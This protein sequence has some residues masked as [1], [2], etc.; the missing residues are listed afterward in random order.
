MKE[1]SF[2]ADD[3]GIHVPSFAG[4]NVVKRACENK[5]LALVSLSWLRF[6]V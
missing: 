5:G 1:T 2:G 6:N 3:D 4:R